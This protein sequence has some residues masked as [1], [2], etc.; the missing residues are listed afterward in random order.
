MNL[1][2]VEYLFFLVYYDV[3]GRALPRQTL[4]G[5]IRPLTLDQLYPDRNNSNNP[6]MEDIEINMRFSSRFL[7]IRLWEFRVSQIPFSQRAPAGC[8]QYHTGTEGIIQ[9]IYMGIYIR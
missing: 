2:N 8:V 9:V 3:G 6:E 5:A 1:E 7:P 4:F